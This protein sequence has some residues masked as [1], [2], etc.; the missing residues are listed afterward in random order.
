MNIEIKKLTPEMA[1]AYAHF[2]D[3]TPHDVNVDEQKCYCIT[4]RSDSTYANGESHWFPTREE[5]RSRAIEY[6]KSG[7]IKGY[8][9]FLE[10][11]IIGWCN[12]NENCSMCVSY[13]SAYWP[14][15]PKSPETKAKYV[16]CFMISPKMQ[17]KG[18]ATQ[19]L[20]KVCEDAK[21]EGFD[22]VEAYVNKDSSAEEHDF[23]G[24]IEMYLKCGFEIYAEKEDRVVVR[25]SF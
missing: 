6:I 24:P 13:L 22:Y 18:V 25:R 20:Q 21:E 7:G 9:A 5:R 4:W 14:I 15:E 12:T 3:V 2:F 16:F 23:R 11:E 17:H 10:G 19:I 8:L 1:E